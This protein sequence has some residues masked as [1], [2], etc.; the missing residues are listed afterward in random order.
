V[1]LVL[2]AKRINSEFRLIKVRL[3]EQGFPVF[4]N[5][6]CSIPGLIELF[7]ESHG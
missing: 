4:M 6:K 2:R 3:T 1:D 7:A 5:I